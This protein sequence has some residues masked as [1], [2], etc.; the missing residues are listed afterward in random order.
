M[1]RNPLCHAR[2][3][4]QRGAVLP[5]SLF[6]LLIVTL[7]VVSSV[8]TTNTGLRTAFN[9]QALTVATLTSVQRIEQVL[10]DVGWFTAGGGA[11]DFQDLEDNDG[12]D[13]EQHTSTVNGYT[14]VVSK[15]ECVGVVDAAGYSIQVAFP[16][17]I[18]YWEFA[19]SAEDP[20]TGAQV[21]SR[22]GVRIRMLNGSC[23]AL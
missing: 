18:T 23:Q 20:V 21:T 15:P 4:R 1:T 12:A 3:A 11:G 17:Q 6:I 5:V 7:L 19:V 13:D 8:D 22:Q 10:G 14:V 9:Q 2:V 16:P